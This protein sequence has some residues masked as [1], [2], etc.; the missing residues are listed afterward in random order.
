ME[1][2]QN[3]PIDQVNQNGKPRHRIYTVAFLVGRTNDFKNAN[4]DKK[5]TEIHIFSC[6]VFYSTINFTSRKRLNIPIAHAIC[7]ELGTGASL[8][9]THGVQNK[10]FDP[11]TL[12]NNILFIRSRYS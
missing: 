6:F 7:T 1:M 2:V 8:G 3:C 12:P 11:Y 4:V 5:Y 9:E 10:H